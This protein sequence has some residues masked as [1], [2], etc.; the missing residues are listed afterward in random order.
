MKGPEFSTFCPD[1]SQLAPL[2][3]IASPALTSDS[4]HFP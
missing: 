4:G 3:Q 2:S 1:G